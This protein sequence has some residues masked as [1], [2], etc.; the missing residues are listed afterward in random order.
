MGVERHCILKF[1][2]R[3]RG[4]TDYMCMLTRCVQR[5]RELLADGAKAGEKLAH[6]VVRRNRTSGPSTCTQLVVLV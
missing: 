3:P 1:G 2:L 6:A 4:P 5:E